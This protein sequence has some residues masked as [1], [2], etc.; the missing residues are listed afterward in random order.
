MIYVGGG[1]GLMALAII[2]LI[3]SER[4]WLRIVCGAYVG[5]YAAV[6]AYSIAFGGAPVRV[7]AVPATFALLA[8]FVASVKKTYSKW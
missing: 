1:A 7:L 2:G 3:L 6:V 8:L 4:L 5:L